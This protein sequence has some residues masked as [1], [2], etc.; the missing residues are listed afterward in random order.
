MVQVVA[1]SI[2]YALL[3]PVA[4]AAAITAASMAATTWLRQ[5]PRVRRYLWMTL[6]T[7]VSIPS[8]NVSTHRQHT[9]RAP[10]VC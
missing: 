7:Q 10:T 4:R 8:R 5:P 2:G 3:M 6:L 9:D 1:A